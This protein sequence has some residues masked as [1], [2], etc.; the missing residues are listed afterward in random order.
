MIRV[1]G[2][3]YGGNPKVP[4][5]RMERSE[6]SWI[7]HWRVMG[8]FPMDGLKINYRANGYRLPSTNE[9]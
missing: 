1:K 4:P 3:S 7:D 6:V 9:G 5:F 8:T 2:G